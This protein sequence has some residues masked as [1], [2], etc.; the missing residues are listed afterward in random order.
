MAPRESVRRRDDSVGCRG[1]FVA[2]EGRQGLKH[3]G[4]RVLSG[5]ASLQLEATSNK[6]LL[7]K[8]LLALLR[9]ERSDASNIASSI[10]STS[11]GFGWC[12]RSRT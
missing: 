3:R 12:A 4:P 11:D 10:A 6:K 7:K 1:R 2:G 5:I 9:T 8:G